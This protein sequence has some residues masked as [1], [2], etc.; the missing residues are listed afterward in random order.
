M[1]RSYD[2]YVG[3]WNDNDIEVGQVDLVDVDQ[4]RAGVQVELRW[5]GNT[6]TELNQFTLRPDEDGDLLIAS[7]TS[8]G[9]D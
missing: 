7:Q 2:Y 5:N 1:A 4:D 3:F 9:D 8:S 6:T